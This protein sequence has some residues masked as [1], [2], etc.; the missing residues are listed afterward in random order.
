MPMKDSYYESQAIRNDLRTARVPLVR[1]PLET[2]QRHSA[3]TGSPRCFRKDPQERNPLGV[4]NPLE[5]IP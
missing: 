3:L 1:V 2:S 4:R 5:Q